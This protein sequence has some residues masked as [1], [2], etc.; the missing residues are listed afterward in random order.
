LKVLHCLSPAEFI[1]AEE[2]RESHCLIMLDGVLRL[3]FV[4]FIT[5]LAQSTYL[6]GDV[7]IYKNNVHELTEKHNLAT[8]KN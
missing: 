5:V 2:S 6:R 4:V 3:Y 1:A 8:S 7:L